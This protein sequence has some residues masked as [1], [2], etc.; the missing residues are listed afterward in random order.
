MKHARLLIALVVV[1]IIAAFEVGTA[2]A[3]E[4]EPSGG[5][6]NLTKDE[7]IYMA[8]ARYGGDGLTANEA[9]LLWERHKDWVKR[10]PIVT[11]YVGDGEYRTSN[12]G[13]GRCWVWVKA[14]GKSFN[15]LAWP[16]PDAWVPV[17]EI[18]MET[19]WDFDGWRVYPGSVSHSQPKFYPIALGAWDFNGTVDTNDYYVPAGASSKAQYHVERLYAF[20]TIEVPLVGALIDDNMRAWLLERWNGRWS[21][22]KHDADHCTDGSDD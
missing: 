3:A 6:G 16:G 21:M 7:W 22:A 13:S 19:A 15:P 18:R 4:P 17:Y 5:S 12:F 20:S 14:V 9:R 10:I 1:I 8:V 11:R 2:R